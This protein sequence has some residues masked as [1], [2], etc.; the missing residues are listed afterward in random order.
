MCVKQWL[1]LILSMKKSLLALLLICMTINAFGQQELPL[2][3]GD[4]PF[5]T[6]CPQKEYNPAPGRVQGVTVPTLTVYLPNKPDSAK[7]AIIIC[8]GG[9]YTRLSIDPEG[10]DVAQ[11]LASQGIAAFVLKYRL[12]LDTCMTNKTLV[13]LTDA[14]AALQM[15]KQRA[16]DWNINPD[17]VGIMGFSAGGHLASTVATHF[18]A[19]EQRP[20]FAI[21][22]YPV[23]S[24]ADS[25]AHKGSRDNLAGKNASAELIA[26]YSN[27]TRVT[28]QTPPCFIV[29]AADD[30]TVKV[31]NGLVFY[32]ALLKNKVPAE[33]HIYQTG[34]HGF[35][36]KHAVTKDQWL[37]QSIQWLKLVKGE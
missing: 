5:A 2:Y 3:P 28:P 23:I 9:G 29:F 27:E 24:F 13:P 35:G 15:V 34:G 18:T 37:H 19:K 26:N 25:L 21:L 14:Q 20:A 30:K 32:E 31:Q 11:L 7:T 8:P 12:P 6:P 1:C 33:L 16:A 4:I 22:V 10:H 36:I 17:R